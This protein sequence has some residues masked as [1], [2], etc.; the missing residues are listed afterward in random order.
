MGIRIRVLSLVPVYYE[1][2]VS[3]NYF[4]YRY[5]IIIYES[6]LKMSPFSY[7]LCF[8]VEGGHGVIFRKYPLPHSAL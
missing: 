5:F 4:Y 8:F 3:G 6:A 1:Y 2:M 7:N